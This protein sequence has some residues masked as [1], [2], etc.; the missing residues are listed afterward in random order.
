MPGGTTSSILNHLKRHHNDN[1]AVISF[2]E[3]KDTAGKKRKL[4]RTEST[5]TIEKETI[6][7]VNFN[8]YISLGLRNRHK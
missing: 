4:E 6:Q 3:Q 8:N 1:E 5:A 2:I 7:K